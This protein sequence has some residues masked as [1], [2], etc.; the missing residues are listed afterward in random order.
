MTD[1]NEQA[2]Q[3]DFASKI[4]SDRSVPGRNKSDQEAKT[5]LQ[6]QAEQRAQWQA[7]HP[8]EVPSEAPAE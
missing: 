5:Y 7:E 3:I 4:Y 8:D 2:N 6:A 1:S